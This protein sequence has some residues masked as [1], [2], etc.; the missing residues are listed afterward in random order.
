[1]SSL[2]IFFT[3]IVYLVSLGLVDLFQMEN[4]VPGRRLPVLARRGSFGS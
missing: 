4:V 1:M 2:L 3:R